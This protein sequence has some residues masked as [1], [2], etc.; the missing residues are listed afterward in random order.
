ML[1]AAHIVHQLRGRLRLRVREKCQDQEFFDEV[2]EC[3]SGLS[4]ITEVKINSTTGSVLLLHPEA[5]CLEVEAQLR[6]LQLFD[7]TDAPEPQAP[8][9]SPVLSGLSGINQAL[10]SGSAGSTDLRTV[11]FVGV[12]A[13]VLRQILRGQIIG[14]AL[15]MVVMALNLLK[16]VGDPGADSES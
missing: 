9:L 1:P 14:P 6:E 3:L 10:S 11:A 13:L 5:T 8:A 16:S 15:P 12:M 7:L 2:R 4:T